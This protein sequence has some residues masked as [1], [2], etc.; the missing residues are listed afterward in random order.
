MSFF[1]KISRNLKKVVR[2]PILASV[3]AGVAIVFPVVGVPALAALATAN[4]ALKAAETSK[5]QAQ[6]L[7]KLLTATKS[8]AQQGN[9]G[10]KRALE[11]FTVVR[12]AQRGNPKALAK[13]QT[14]ARRASVGASIANRY[15]TQPNGRLR[16]V[17]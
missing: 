2:S 11:A 14:I 12:A 3:T 17:A 10:A 4:A 13:V 9:P 5:A 8:A 7:T 15:R 16:K 6:K 1:K